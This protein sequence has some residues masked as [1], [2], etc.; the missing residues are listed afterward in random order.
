MTCIIEL[1]VSVSF[2]LKRFAGLGGFL[3]AWATT[4]ITRWNGICVC[5]FPVNLL[6]SQNNNISFRGLRKRT[7]IHAWALLSVHDAALDIKI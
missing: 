1:S 3:I 2:S 5:C 7:R 6:L 4:S